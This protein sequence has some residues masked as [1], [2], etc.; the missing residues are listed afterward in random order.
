MR[1]LQRWAIVLLLAAGCSEETS[2]KD[3]YKYTD[4]GPDGEE[5]TVKE[6]CKTK[7]EEDW[8]GDYECNTTCSCEIEGENEDIEYD[9][10][11]H[12]PYP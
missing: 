9:C 5:I 10:D 11:I 6:C 12:Y 4:T 1:L 3:C 2:Y 7:C 8:D